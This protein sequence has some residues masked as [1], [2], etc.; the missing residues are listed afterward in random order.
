MMQFKNPVYLYFLFLLL[1]PIIIHL[2]QLR[3]FKKT[4]FTNV[5]LLKVLSVQSRKSSQIKKW[6]VLSLRMLTIASFVLAFAQPFIPA[7][8]EAS[9]KTVY[10]VYLDNSFSMQMPSKRG[11]LLTQAKQE[12]V[13][14]IPENAT[15]HFFTNQDRFT[16]LNAATFKKE[17]LAIEFSDQELK[18]ENAV[19]KAKSLFGNKN[20]NNKI[21]L[22]S[23]FQ[24]KDETDYAALLKD[25]S[26][27]LL[28]VQPENKINFS[29]ANLD[30]NENEQTLKI[31]LSASEQTQE[32]V[33]LSVYNASEL[34]A[35]QEVAFENSAST[36]I[37]IS[38]SEGEITNGNVQI[39]D[40]AIQYD[41]QFFFSINSTPKIKVLA[42]YE[43]EASFLRRIFKN[44]EFEF[45]STSIENLDYA[46]LNE[47]NIIVL[48]GVK[49]IS[50]QLNNSLIKFSE[51][52]GSVVII[53]H[54]EAK[55][56]NYN[57]TLLNLNLPKFNAAIDNEQKITN[58]NFEHPLLENVFTEQITNFEYPLTRSH[59]QMKAG[60]NAILLYANQEAFL[61]SADKN[62]V[63]A[64]SFSTENSNFTNSPLIVP[65]LY[66]IARESV[67]KQN[68]F[69]FT[70]EIN[71]YLVEVNLASDEVVK[72]TK[73][74]DVLIPQQRRFSQSVEINTPELPI[75]AGTYQV[76][77]AGETLK[78][79]SFNYP[80][81]ESKLDYLQANQLQNQ[82]RLKSIEDFFNQ[83]SRLQQVDEYWKVLLMFAILF[84]ILE[85]LALRYLK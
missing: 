38:L 23:D 59:F 63:F 27:S 40:E 57:T 79:I 10:A 75:E 28:Q 66:N 17:V 52:A 25:E 26:I 78:N 44:E 30:F 19:N 22:V 49:N 21:V 29:I 56:E 70:D 12:L 34:L 35:K 4:A 46:Q 80:R 72:L 8:T 18:I 24:L 69:D 7:S 33:E 77:A 65:I 71:Q 64:A 16:N 39:E 53:P 15:V 51:D 13:E 58:I 74:E 5:A 3:R 55:L 83:E 48:N 2:F 73:D 42:I 32:Q 82:D 1:V 20:A 50:N 37:E 54:Q 31:Q 84:L 36:E 9:Q 68:I 85:M 61:T 62:Y 14:L 45:E 67:L 43:E 81:T 76:E 60:N 41:N 47:K 11:N 6:I